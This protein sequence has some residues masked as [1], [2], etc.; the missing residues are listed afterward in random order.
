VLKEYVVPMSAQNPPLTRTIT[1]FFQELGAEI[2]E[3][4]AEQVVVALNIEARHM[5]IASNLH[6][7]VIASLMDVAMGQA[8]TY[9][10]KDEERYLAMT[11]SLNVNFCAPAKAGSR[12]RA[13]ARRRS[14]GHKI[15]MVACDLHDE[16]GQLLAFGEGVFKRGV[17]WADLP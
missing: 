9:S 12:V 1:G 11:L 10:P 15:S 7:G 6:G 13:V 3:Y 5:N 4:S 16:Q 2:E 8:A 14:G 17:L